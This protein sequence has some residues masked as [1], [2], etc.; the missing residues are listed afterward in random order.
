MHCTM[1][2][3]PRARPDDHFT[4]DQW[5]RLSAKSSWR[6]LW[7]V[8]H[9][10]GTIGLAMLVGARWPLLLPLCVLVIGTRQLGLAILMHDAAHGLLHPTAPCQ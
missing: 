1:A 7:L 8:A 6:G 4:P 9:A 3:A 10:W 2:I 5:R